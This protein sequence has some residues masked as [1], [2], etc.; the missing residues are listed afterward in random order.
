MTFRLSIL[1][2]YLLKSA[3][4]LGITTLSIVGSFA[5][6]CTNDIKHKVRLHVELFIVI[7]SVAFAGLYSLNL[8]SGVNLVNNRLVMLFFGTVIKYM[9]Y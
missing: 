3:T 9:L 2:K 1:C 5:T 8:G 4:T 7:P 6:L